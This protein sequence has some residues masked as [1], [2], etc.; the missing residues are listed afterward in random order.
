MVAAIPNLQTGSRLLVAATALCLMPGMTAWAF[1]LLDQANDATVPTGTEL[2]A[3]DVND[4]RHQLQLANGLATRAG[5]G[6][7]I[8]PRVSFEE[9]FTDNVEQLN[10]P[11]RWDLGTFVSPGVTV[12]G[13]T[14]RVQL[15]FDYSP[16]LALYART[17][18][19][20]ALSHRLSGTALVTVVPDLFFVDM[21]AIAGVQSLTGGI[22][23][24]GVGALANTG[25]IAPGL[26]GNAGVNGIARQNQAQTAS[27]GISPYLLG[28]FGDYGNG[29]LGYSFDYSRFS[30]TTGFLSAPFPT[31]GADGQSQ[32][33]T[34][35]YAQFTSGE[36]LGAFQNTIDVDLSQSDSTTQGA[37]LDT[38][39]ANLPGTNTHSTRQIVS[40]KLA[41]A[42][43]RN[44]SLF[45][46]IGHENI[47]YGNG[48]L[49]PIN[50]V[51]WSVGTTITPGP[52]SQITVSY[53][54]QQGADAFS[55]DG[56]YALT[57]RTTI[58]GSY[59]NTI[60][61]QLENLQT[62]LNQS[63]F[64][65]NGQFVNSQSGSSPL[66]LVNS[67]A[68]QPGV[69]RFNTVDLNV[70]TTLDRDI[71]SLGLIYSVQTSTGG[72]VTTANSSTV[73]TVTSQWV[74][75]LRPDLLSI[76]SISYS[77][78]NFANGGGILGGRNTTIAGAAALQ[79]TISDTLNASLRYAYY[80]R[81]GGATA[82]NIYQNLLIL[83]IT[84][85]F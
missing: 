11:R 36:G 70:Q 66:G 51:T 57:A 19:K 50:D 17:G 21:R 61:T 12:L 73:K 77:Q 1:P 71:L 13:D 20:N 34:E 37:G 67:L 84:K 83:S 47:T 55:A 76:A 80:G 30:R 68:L 56:H 85:Q 16:T 58:S 14:Q 62:Q 79:Y 22:G 54:H 81:N 64:N 7:T 9:M 82:Q 52:D 49:R 2:A 29:R 24:G 74:H 25:L 78:Q 35:E 75:Q 10:A 18:S 39:G 4:L 41:Y 43:N 26:A 48:V 60:G 59:S 15:K 40:D 33:T 8:L 38:I 28:S 3:P 65:A 23:A 31:G 27:F 45:V 63:R 72:G 5:G 44:V 6:W 32:L 53:G 46:T 69:F 42:V